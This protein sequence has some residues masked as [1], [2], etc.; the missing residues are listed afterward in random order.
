M[1]PLLNNKINEIILELVDKDLV[2][3][4][5]PNPVPLELRVNSF[6]DTAISKIE[7]KNGLILEFG[8]Y[9]GRT[10]NY[11]ASK[12]PN[13]T[14]YGFD[15][16]EGLPEEWNDQNPKGI[17]TLNGILP[18]VE[19]NVKLIK[20]LF[21]ETLPSF[22]KEHN[23]PISLLHIDCDIYLSTACVLELLKDQIIDGKII[24]FD[25]IWKYPNYRDHE[26]KAFAEFLLKYNFK[27]ECLRV[28]KS[29]YASA[30]F[31]LKK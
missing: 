6:L 14:V 30:I 26:I 13:Q 1:L 17:Y 28:I 19:K 16:F 9:K 5:L 18:K 22:I 12:V 10:V 3:I 25:E 24:I 29:R 7:V 8:V 2:N 20:G 27:Y 4:D 21:H 31:I 15:S 23:D 11:L